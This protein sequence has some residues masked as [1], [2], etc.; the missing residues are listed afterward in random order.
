MRFEK[1]EKMKF[2]GLGRYCNIIL[3]YGIYFFLLVS[4]TP[5]R[6]HKILLF[7]YTI[8][9]Q[10]QWSRGIAE[11]FLYFYCFQRKEEEIGGDDFYIH[12]YLYFLLEY[13]HNEMWLSYAFFSSNQ[14]IIYFTQKIF[15]FRIQCMRFNNVEKYSC[16]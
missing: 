16:A 2:V 11:I 4:L 14:N 9:Q 15:V 6:K 3:L 13:M 10:S 5:K 12:V 1:V 8:R 7:I